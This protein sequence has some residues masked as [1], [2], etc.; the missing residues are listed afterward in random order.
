M[1]PV[2]MNAGPNTN[3]ILAGDPKQLGPIVRSPIAEKLGLGVSW[4]DR[5]M[6]LPLYEPRVYSGVT[7]A[8][9]TPLGNFLCTSAEA[10]SRV[11]KLLKNWRS[12]RSILKFPNAEFYRDELQ[13]HADPVIVDSLLRFWQLP[14]QG[15]PI[16]FNAIKG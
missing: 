10:N 7:Y 2:K 15:F 1:I 6:S 4:L 13:A 12:H 16:I 11:V 3:I 14:R 5:L 9:F 8:L